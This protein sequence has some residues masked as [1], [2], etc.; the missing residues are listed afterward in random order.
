MKEIEQIRKLLDEVE[1]KQQTNQ[2]TN[3]REVIDFL[4]G[5]LVS[6]HQ[7]SQSFENKN[8]KSK[9]YKVALYMQ[10]TAIRYTI[11]DVD[12]WLKHGIKP[13]GLNK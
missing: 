6:I 12:L 7:E 1:L 3:E 8:G 5:R 2:K 4:L 11:N 13:E 10:R 9:S